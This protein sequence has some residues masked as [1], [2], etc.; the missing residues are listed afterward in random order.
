MAND[1]AREIRWRVTRTDTAE[2]WEGAE[3][4]G[5]ATDVPR[6]LRMAVR[7]LGL[8]GKA[9]ISDHPSTDDWTALCEG[10]E[11]RAHRIRPSSGRPGT[12]V[13]HAERRERGGEKHHFVYLDQEAQEALGRGV[14]ARGSQRAA[15]EHALRETFPPHARGAQKK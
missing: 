5:A 15:I 10:I 12:A 8:S 13:P 2:S 14:K 3:G 11:L 9:E 6:V 4:W 7:G 1:T